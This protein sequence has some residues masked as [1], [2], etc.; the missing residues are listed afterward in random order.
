MGS[1]DFCGAREAFVGRFP[2]DHAPVTL[3]MILAS[4][5]LSLSLSLS[6]RSMPL[7]A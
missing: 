3:G 2:S 5:S 7:P 4:L 6:P 1:R